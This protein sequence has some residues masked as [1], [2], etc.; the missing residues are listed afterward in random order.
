M[1]SEG[2][3]ILVV[4]DDADFVEIE[5]TILEEAGYSVL[6]AYSGSECLE[7]MQREIPDL[8][9]LDIA[10]TKEYEGTNVA[11]SL[12]DREETRTIPILVVTSKPLYSIYPDEEWYP[13]DDF[14]NKPIDRAVLLEKVEKLIKS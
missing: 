8:I 13:T 9:I 3:K 6:A 4:D 10:M 7:I 1:A 2:K 5:K 11:Q 14:I 12:R